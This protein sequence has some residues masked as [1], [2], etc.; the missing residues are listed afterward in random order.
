MKRSTLNPEGSEIRSWVA[1]P[2]TIAVQAE[3]IFV[4]R[5]RPIEFKGATDFLL[6][7]SEYDLDL[8]DLPATLSMADETY[9]SVLC[10]VVKTLAEDTHL[11]PSQITDAFKAADSLAPIPGRTIARR[12]IRRGSTAFTTGSSAYKA[13][14]G[15]GAISLAGPM[16][17]LGRLGR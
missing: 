2:K 14:F 9:P 12:P 11:H 4:F 15:T 16:S 6:V 17:D 8:E 5:I 13:G 1:K 10:A 7:V 3:E